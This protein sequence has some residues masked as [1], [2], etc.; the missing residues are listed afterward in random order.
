MGKE[1]PIMPKEF[2]GEQLTKT[3]YVK[4]APRRWTKEEIGWCL[5][6]R[7]EGFN[8]KDIA[9]STGREEVSVSIKMKRLTKKDD[10]YNK[11]HIEEKYKVNEVYCQDLKPK[12]ILDVYCGKKSYWRTNTTSKVVTNDKDI[13]IVA[14]YHMDALKFLCLQYIENNKY[15]LIDLDPFGSTYECLDLAIKMSKKGLIVTLGE[16]GH[17]RFKRLDFVRRMYGIE[18]LEDFTTETI[19]KEIQKIGLK[20]KK[21]LKVHTLKEWQG[22]SRV[23]FTIEEYKVVEQWS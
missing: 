5:K 1:V 14:D 17:K 12:K 11:K 23:W 4:N 13:E 2:V 8:V 9:L 21:I 20:N 22:I 15:D 3:E 7:E 16:M 19:I 10:S 6:L 18:T